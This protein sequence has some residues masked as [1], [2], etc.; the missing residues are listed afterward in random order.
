MC[1]GDIFVQRGAPMESGDVEQGEAEEKE[2]E[3]EE[4]KVKL[5]LEDG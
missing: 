1:C 2:G 4:R 5:R 3:K